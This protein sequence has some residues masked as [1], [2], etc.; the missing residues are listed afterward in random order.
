MLFRFF[1]KNT[2]KI[3]YF[4]EATIYCSIDLPV[5]AALGHPLEGKP[6]WTSFTTP[7]TMVENLFSWDSCLTLESKQLLA[8]SMLWSLAKKYKA[9]PR[10]DKN[11]PV[12]KEA[13]VEKRTQLLQPHPLR[14]AFE[15]KEVEQG[16]H[17]FLP[18]SHSNCKRS[19]TAEKEQASNP[20]AKK[21]KLQTLKSIRPMDPANL[22]CPCCDTTLPT[23]SGYDYHLSEN[24]CQTNH[25][26][27]DSEWQCDN[28]AQYFASFWT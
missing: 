2:E 23:S 1:Y 28:C 10:F 3:S 8:N 7:G 17:P 25:N 15:F 22:T 12:Y 24:V 9:Q 4:C 6:A 26:I 18:S 16:A 14:S 21:P 5:T 27:A 19:Y 13:E 11:A 20:A